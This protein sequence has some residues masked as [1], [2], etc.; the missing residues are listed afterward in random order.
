MH[1]HIMLILSLLAFAQATSFP[2]EDYPPSALRH[3]LEGVVE[4]EVSIDAAGKV[5]ECRI[6]KSSHHPVLDNATCKLVTRRGKFQP[7]IGPDGKAIPSVVKVPPVEWKLP[8]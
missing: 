4:T 7:A 8:R 3:K 5:T 1:R 6:I 2:P